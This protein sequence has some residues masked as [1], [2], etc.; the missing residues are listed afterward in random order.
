MQV[1][2]GV[3]GPDLFARQPQKVAVE[4]P[5][6]EE[7]TWLTDINRDGRQDI[8]MHHPFTRRDAHGAPE[9]AAGHRTAARHD[10]SCTVKNQW[11]ISRIEA[12]VELVEQQTN[13]R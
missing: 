12:L 11:K 7:Y 5:N 4:L 10:V 6:D 8:V 13:S 9:N 3:P 2:A 1:Y